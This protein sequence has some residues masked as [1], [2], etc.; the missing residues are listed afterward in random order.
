MFVPLPDKD[1]LVLIVCNT[2]NHVNYIADALKGIVKQKT[3]FPFVALVVDDCSTDGTQEIIRQYESKYPDLIKAIYHEENYWSIRKNPED[4]IQ[5]WRE[6]SKYQAFCEGDDFWTDPLKLQKQADF[7]EANPDCTMS[8]HTV[9]EHWEDNNCSDKVFYQVENR[10]YTGTEI[11]KQWIVAT[12]SVMGRTCI[13][14]SPNMMRNI[15]NP[16]FMYYDLI[17]QLTCAQLGKVIGLRDNMAVYRRTNSGFTH[18]FHRDMKTSANVV[19]NYCIH[20]YNLDKYFSDSFGAEFHDEVVKRFV[21]AATGG[22]KS[23]LLQGNIKNALF[24]IRESLSYYTKDTLLFYKGI[25]YRKIKNIC[26]S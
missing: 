23:Q 6:R 14:Q 26:G 18:Q 8:F 1:Y 16:N 5:L 4:D 21:G 25:L 20:N 10:E 15:Y 12:A 22:V 19:W 3:S 17:V 13:A 7:M 11:V 2:Y 24:F 9:T